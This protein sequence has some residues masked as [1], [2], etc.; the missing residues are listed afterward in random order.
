MKRRVMSRCSFVLENSPR[1]LSQP[2]LVIIPLP[3][4]HMAPSSTPGEEA[5]LLLMGW[6][7]GVGALEE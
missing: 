6:G 3:H 1:P 7:T 4:K 5:S 2:L